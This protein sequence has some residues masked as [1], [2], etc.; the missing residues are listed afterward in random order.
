MLMDTLKGH[1]Y[2]MSPW[3]YYEVMSH[4]DAEM[5]YVVMESVQSLFDEL[6]A[7]NEKCS[8][9]YLHKVFIKAAVE[10]ICER[11]K[12]DARHINKDRILDKVTA[13]RINLVNTN[14]EVSNLP[15]MEI[16]NVLLKYAILDTLVQIRFKQ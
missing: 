6:R 13:A 8:Y 3:Q 15:A 9:Y 12:F 14:K 7:R 10:V 1:T 4:Y 16:V 5:Q 11:E 2:K